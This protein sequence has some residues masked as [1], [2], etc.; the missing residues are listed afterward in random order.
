MSLLI[1]VCWPDLLEAG[2][3]LESSAP[4]DAAC[5]AKSLGF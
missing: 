4:E 1:V 5:R 2:V 3:K